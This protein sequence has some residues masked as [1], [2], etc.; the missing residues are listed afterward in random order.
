M[1]ETGRG[2]LAGPVV[3]SAV[4]LGR[5]WNENHQLDDS[6]ALKV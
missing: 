1:D 3:V 4:I 2:P 6:K 5:N